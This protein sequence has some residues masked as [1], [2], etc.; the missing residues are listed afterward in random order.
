[1]TS[2][3][4]NYQ[5]SA[6]IITGIGGVTI[7]GGRIMN[8]SSNEFRY[9]ISCMLKRS[10]T[11]QTKTYG[12]VQYSNVMRGASGSTDIYSGYAIGYANISSGFN[13]GSSDETGIQYMDITSSQGLMGILTSGI[14]GSLRFGNDGVMSCNLSITSGGYGGLGIDKVIY[15]EIGG[16]PITVRGL[17][18][19]N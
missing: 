6:I 16:V 17:L 4:A 10:S 3:L 14:G 18:V 1:M 7:T 5:N 12:D 11:A 8:S 13:L 9:I 19:R 2:V 15:S